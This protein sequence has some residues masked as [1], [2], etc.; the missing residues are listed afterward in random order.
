M[1]KITFNITHNEVFEDFAKQFNG[2]NPKHF[3][4]VIN[5]DEIIIDITGTLEELDSE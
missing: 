3:I 5:D 2:Q 4:I 1:K